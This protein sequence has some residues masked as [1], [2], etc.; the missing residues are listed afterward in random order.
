MLSAPKVAKLSAP[1]VATLSAPKVATLSAP[2][3]AKL[4][5]PKVAKLISAPKVAILSAISRAHQRGTVPNLVQQTKRPPEPIVSFLLEPAHHINTLSDPANLAKRKRQQKVSLGIDSSD[6]SFLRARRKQSEQSHIGLTKLRSVVIHNNQ[7]KPESAE[8]APDK[9]ANKPNN[10]RLIIAH[11]QDSGIIHSPGFQHLTAPQQKFILDHASTASRRIIFDGRQE[12]ANENKD[13]VWRRWTHFCARGGLRIDP[14]LTSLLSNE[15]ELLLR[16]FLGLY[17]TAT[18]SCSG[19]LT[20]SRRTPVAGGTVRNA[21]SSLATAF[22]KNHQPSPLHHQ[23]GTNLQHV[24]RSLLRA[25]DNQDPAPTRQK[26]ITPRLLLALY[27][28]SGAK[29]V[30][31]RDSAPSVTADLVLG[32]FFFACRACEYTKTK[33]PGKTKVI[34]LGGVIFR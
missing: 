19:E 18:W 5:A 7:R 17:R 22:R 25:Y 11:E 2:K 29:T 34:V 16:S 15:Q 30:A 9:L 32:S 4:N 14:F 26:A 8:T 12:S 33:L 3:V 6:P 27:D 1:T 20:G 10:H 31:L 13:R 24:F 23:S 21:A 28:S